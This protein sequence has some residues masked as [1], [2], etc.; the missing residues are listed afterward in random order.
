MSMIL[1]T[2]SILCNFNLTS[3]ANGAGT[4][5]GV[6]AISVTILYGQLTAQMWLKK[7]ISESESKHKKR[8]FKASTCLLVVVPLAVST[9]F[10]A[11]SLYKYADSISKRRFTAIPN[12]LNAIF[13]LSP[14]Q[15]LSFFPLYKKTR[16]STDPEEDSPGPDS[17]TLMEDGHESINDNYTEEPP[18]R[19]RAH[20]T[21]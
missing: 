16:L 7:K 20:T 19:T 4:A 8:C 3:L 6:L 18:M 17:Y 5:G 11:L 2:L 9:I 15:I 1:T 14:L 21:I 13:Y 12:Y 10:L